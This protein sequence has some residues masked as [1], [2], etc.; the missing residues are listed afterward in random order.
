MYPT[1]ALCSLR[2]VLLP[3]ETFMLCRLDQQRLLITRRRLHD[4]LLKLFGT[5]ELPTMRWPYPRLSKN[6]MWSSRRIRTT[7]LK[8]RHSRMR[9]MLWDCP[10]EEL[11][12]KV[13]MPCY[14]FSVLLLN[15]FRCD[16]V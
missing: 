13:L 2:L 12:S 1:I 5:A 14:V 16:L 4:P 6:T 7:R 3:W 15:S 9:R 8:Q 10:I 11:R